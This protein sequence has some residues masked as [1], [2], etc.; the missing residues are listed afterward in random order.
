[1]V[2][3]GCTSAETRLRRF[4]KDLLKEQGPAPSDG[5]ICLHLPVKQQELA[6]I[7]AISPEYL[8]RL[9]KKIEKEGFI[10]VHRGEVVV[11]DP[12][13]FLKPSNS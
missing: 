3:L 4:L 9:L 7:I 8:C 2:A 10:T 12:S 5:T 1:M 11:T 13:G 6:Q